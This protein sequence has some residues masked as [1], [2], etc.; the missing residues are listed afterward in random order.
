MCWGG[1]ARMRGLIVCLARGGYT[2]DSADD[3]GLGRGMEALGVPV[4]HVA[5]FMSFVSI[6]GHRVNPCQSCQ[7][8]VFVSL[9]ARATP[10]QIRPHPGDTHWRSTRRMLAAAAAPAAAAASAT[11][12]AVDA[13]VAFR[14]AAAAASPPPPPPP[15]AAAA[16]AAA[17][18]TVA[19][20]AVEVAVAEGR[21]DALKF[22]GSMLAFRF[23]PPAPVPARGRRVADIMVALRP[24]PPPPGPPVVMAEA[25][26]LVAPGA[27]AAASAPLF[28]S[29]LNSCGCVAFGVVGCRLVAR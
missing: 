14:F 21:N 18:A 29:Q 6:R 2:L 22:L 5:S 17:L 27:A 3:G 8:V 20:E 26:R 7:S 1:E 16:P 4:R 25:L 19:L 15:A 11:L 9:D 24:P 10:T 13:M 23:T 12:A 28:T